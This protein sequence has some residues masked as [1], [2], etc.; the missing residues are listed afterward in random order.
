MSKR[1]ALPKWM[2]PPAG[3]IAGWAAGVTAGAPAPAAWTIAGIATWLA[4]PFNWAFMV[5]G[6]GAG[7]GS[8][9]SLRGHFHPEPPP[10]V[11]FTQVTDKLG[12]I[13]ASRL[14]ELVGLIRKGALTTEQ[15]RE[16]AALAVESL[17]GDGTANQ[18]L[19]ASFAETIVTVSQSPNLAAREAV[20]LELS[21]NRDQA[22]DQLMSL[23]EQE[24]GTTAE[25]FRQAGAI[26]APTSVA[27][28][29]RAY[30]RAADLEPG[31]YWTWIELARLQRSA[32]ALPSARRCADR[33]LQYAAD[34]RERSICETELGEIALRGNDRELAQ[35]HFEA[36][37]K[38]DEALAKSNPDNPD[39]QRDLSVSYEKLGNL[40]MAAGDLGEAKKYFLMN[41]T[42]TDKLAAHYPEVAETQRDISV[43]YGKLGDVAAKAKEFDTAQSDYEKSLAIRIELAAIDPGYA[44]W[45]RDLSVIY[46]KLGHLALAAGRLDDA[47]SHYSK[48]LAIAESLSAT[49]SENAEWQRDLFYSYI[50]RASVDSAANEHT[51]ALGNLEKAEVLMADLINKV[52][53]HP[54]FARDLAFVQ[55]TISQLK[56]G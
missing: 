34:E 26:A 35:S 4:V 49:D 32:G 19:I 10:A 5:V 42:I 30:T 20:A 52:P 12:E 17:P 51:L 33:A 46:S 44:P 8:Y 29:I 47:R 43:S 50:T 18:P 55:Q 54:S 21:G 14:D 48:D 53:E 25:R 11:D 36:A 7:L 27:R 39:H 23:G 15:A 24:A 37:L 40:A 3:L 1:K 13:V 9:F 6:F 2:L 16:A 56:A 28:A 38:A 41:L 45:Q 31:D 22:F